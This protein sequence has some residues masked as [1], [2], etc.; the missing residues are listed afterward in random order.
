[1]AASRKKCLSTEASPFIWLS[2]R[3]HF[4]R[5]RHQSQS[6]R[7]KVYNW[8]L[9]TMILLSL[10]TSLHYILYIFFFLQTL[11]LSAFISLI[12]TTVYSKKNFLWFCIFYISIFQTES[13]L[14]KC[15]DFKDQLVSPPNFDAKIVDGAAL[16]HIISTASSSIFDDY[17]NTVF[18]PFLLNELQKG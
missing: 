18:I 1:M 12:C 11:P 5:S 3:T 8:L 2:K 14:L 16:V 4:L 10:C 15:L 17:A 6:L 7:Q 9:S 13:N